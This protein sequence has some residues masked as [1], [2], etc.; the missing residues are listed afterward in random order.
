MERADWDA[1]RRRVCDGNAELMEENERGKVEKKITPVQHN[2]N[3]TV[4]GSED[5][6]MLEGR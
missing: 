6:R 3:G 1:R 5:L 2:Y 4:L